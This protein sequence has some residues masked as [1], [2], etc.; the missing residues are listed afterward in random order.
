MR[1]EQPNR[2]RPVVFWLA[3]VWLA[4]WLVLGWAIANPV[5][6]YSTLE[7]LNQTVWAMT[8]PL[9][10]LA[11]MAVPLGALVAGIGALLYSGAEGATVWKV[12]IGILAAYIIAFMVP[13]LGHFP[14]LFGIGGTI[15]LLSFM[16]ILWLWAKERKAL[17]GSSTAGADLKLVGYV[18]MLMAA[19][20]T[21]G[22]A[23]SPF[24]KAFEGLPTPSPIH[25]MIMLALGWVFLF[26]GYYRSRPQQAS[27]E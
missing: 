14:P 2:V 22:V 7:E 21:C 16:G 5:I 9:L 25:L 12:G 17:K 19:W 24:M 27:A 23:Y 26:L 4:G 11:G 13:L 18:F 8:G 10:L 15:I 20:Y 6:K 1:I 3:V